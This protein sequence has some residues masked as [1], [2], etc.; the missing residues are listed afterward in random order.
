M[1]AALIALF[2]LENPTLDVGFKR[3]YSDE[4]DIKTPFDIK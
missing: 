1:S 4:A 2:V 3:A